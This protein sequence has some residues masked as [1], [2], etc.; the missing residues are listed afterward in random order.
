MIYYCRVIFSKAKQLHQIQM[1]NK[2]QLPFKSVN[3]TRSPIS[4][5]TG[6]QSYFSPSFLSGTSDDLNYFFSRHK[7]NVS[8]EITDK[9]NIEV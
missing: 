9:K 5:M 4:L 3:I 1:S 8:C 2:V 6:A 7:I